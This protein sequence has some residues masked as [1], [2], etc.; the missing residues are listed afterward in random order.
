MPTF[1]DPARWRQRLHRAAAALLLAWISGIGG[2][3]AADEG[4][5]YVD[6]WDA[7]VAYAQKVYPALFP[8][9]PTVQPFGDGRDIQH[10]KHG[11]MPYSAVDGCAFSGPIKQRLT[12][13]ASSQRRRPNHDRSANATS[14]PSPD[15][16][17]P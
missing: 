9:A 16:G 14:D 8:G 11:G 5:Y 3:A 4:I 7:I 15:S 6:S 2:P 12:C 17:V 13:L 10:V 1:P